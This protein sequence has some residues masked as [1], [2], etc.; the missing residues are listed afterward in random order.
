MKNQRPASVHSSLRPAKLCGET[1]DNKI[2]MKSQYARSRPIPKA[3][4]LE[5]DIMKISVTGACALLLIGFCSVVA[6]Q[7]FTSIKAVERSRESAVS[8]WERENSDKAS[9][10][11]QYRQECQF[12]RAEDPVNKIPV[13]VLTFPECAVK[14]GS[15]SLAAAIDAAERSVEI[16]A[17][18]RWL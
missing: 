14:V 18:L 6:I 2:K 7:F 8:A 5:E 13:R 9:V 1:I 16:P 12:G 17:P 3:H 4:D 11:S 10:V 15:E